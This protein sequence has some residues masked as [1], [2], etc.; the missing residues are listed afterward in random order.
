MPAVVDHRAVGLPPTR[1]T[2]RALSAG[3][4]RLQNRALKAV[5]YAVFVYLL[6][7]LVPSLRQALH[8]LE[9]VRWEWIVG[10]IVLEVLS[11]SGYVQSWRGIVDPDRLLAADG[12]GTRTATHAAWTQ[13]GAGLIVSGGSLAS[14]GVG[15]RRSFGTSGCRRRRSPSVSSI[16][17]SSTQRSTRWRS[18]CAASDSAS[19]SSAV[20][21][22]RFSPGFPP[23]WRRPGSP[24]R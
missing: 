21:A 20:S 16:S 15:A 19:G 22:I 1:H 7:R 6:L 13:L 3:L 14:I 18:S 2:R 23:A 24:A 9:H 10:A 12:R 11:E 4:T 5:G 17:A 8:S